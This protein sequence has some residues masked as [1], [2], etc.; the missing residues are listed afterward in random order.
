M[1]DSPAASRH[2]PCTPSPRSFPHMSHSPRAFREDNKQPAYSS[3][4]RVLPAPRPRLRPASLHE[5]KTAVGSSLWELGGER[6]VSAGSDT[7]QARLVEQPP[8]MCGGTSPPL[9]HSSP[10]VNRGCRDTAVNC[11]P[12][13]DGRTRERAEKAEAYRDGNL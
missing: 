3:I 10:Y 5:D 13:K 7:L 8:A 4:R 12:P 6:R 11:R 9:L 2:L 1:V